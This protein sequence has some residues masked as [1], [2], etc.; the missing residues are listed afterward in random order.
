LGKTGIC[1]DD[2]PFRIPF[3]QEMHRVFQEQHTNNEEARVVRFR[4]VRC[5][6]FGD[7]HTRNDQIALDVENSRYEDDELADILAIDITEAMQIWE[8]RPVSLFSCL[9]PSCR[10]LLPIRNRTHLLRL[11]RVERYFGLKVGASDLVDFK[12]LCEMI[13]E[14]CAQGLQHSY[15]EQRRAEM[16]IRQARIAQLRKMPFEEYRLTPE[17]R[18]RRNRVLF[19]AGKKCELCYER[20]LLQVHHR[21]Y[22]RY[23]QELLTDLIAL[24]R[25]CHARHHNVL[26]EEAA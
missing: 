19:W 25:P 6:Y 4:E 5:P 10:T 26:P 15:D 16:C 13:C 11:L 14:S 23:G 18:A 21:T 12:T 22:E 1:F 2:V 8:A 9:E 17:W 7:L 20:G 3:P 24:C